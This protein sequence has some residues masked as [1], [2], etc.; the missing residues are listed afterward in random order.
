MKMKALLAGNDI[1]EY[2]GDG[3]KLM[4][5]NGWMEKPPGLGLAK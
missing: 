4:I 5:K 2:V 1:A 3:V